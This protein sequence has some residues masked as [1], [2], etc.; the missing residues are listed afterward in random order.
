MIRICTP[1]CKLVGNVNITFWGR[2][3]S[4]T[5]K[6]NPCSLYRPKGSWKT[7]TTNIDLP[8][9]EGHMSIMRTTLQ[10]SLDDDAMMLGIMKS[11]S[12][13]WRMGFQS[14]RVLTYIISLLWIIL[15]FFSL[16]TY[17]LNIQSGCI[18]IIIW[19][20]M[21]VSNLGLPRHDTERSSLG[22]KFGFQFL[23]KKLPKL[24]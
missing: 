22:K 13:A 5:Q 1:S 9:E 4:S 19:S 8:G 17:D 11:P 18:S 6:T 23:L 16:I 20:D 12:I 3:M 2:R 14:K 15:S 7:I 21:E 10:I 24:L